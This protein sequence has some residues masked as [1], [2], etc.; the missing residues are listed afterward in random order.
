MMKGW[1]DE[2]YRKDEKTEMKE[3]IK[4][5]KVYKWW[6]DRNDRNDER[7]EMIEKIKVWKV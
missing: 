4:V 2:K 3:N 7:I 1:K 5:W 6:K